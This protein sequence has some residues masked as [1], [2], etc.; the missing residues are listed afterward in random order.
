MT[1]TEGMA[2]IEKLVTVVAVGLRTDVALADLADPAGMLN[3]IR[4]N[5][6]GKEDKVDAREAVA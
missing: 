2:S 3:L 6:D 4:T 5:L 1:A